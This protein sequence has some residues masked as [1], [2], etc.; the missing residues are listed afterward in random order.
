MTSL[1]VPRL[2]HLGG[3][4]S[5]VVRAKR[6]AVACQRSTECLYIFGFDG[7]RGHGCEGLRSWI[8]YWSHG[9]V[10]LLPRESYV[11]AVAVSSTVLHHHQL[12]LLHHICMYLGTAISVDPQEALS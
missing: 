5:T 8:G 3:P 6:S 4:F 9:F 12:P 2:E 7:E 1:E 10:P 11:K